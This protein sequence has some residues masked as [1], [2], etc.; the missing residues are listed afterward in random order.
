M[1][2]K[3]M[4]DVEILRFTVDVLFDGDCDGLALRLLE[5]FGNISGVLCATR[6]ELGAVRGMTERAASLFTVMLPVF[7]QALLREDDGRLDSEAA[8]AH[9]ALAYF[10][11]ERLPADLCL[12]LNKDNR[13]IVGERIARENRVRE[14]VSCACRS[15]AKKILWLRYLPYGADKKESIDPARTEEVQSLTVPL[16]ALDI[17]LVDYVEYTPFVMYSLRRAVAGVA[18][19]VPIDKAAPDEYKHINFSAS[20]GEYVRKTCGE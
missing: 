1:K 9:Y 15:G 14:I 8:V 7:R 5:R 2:E 3:N 16:D 12:C 17:E 11:N 18:V 20:T 6:E 13:L 4:S 10:M 19:G